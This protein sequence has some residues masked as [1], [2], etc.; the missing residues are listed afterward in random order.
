MTNE[1]RFEALISEELTAE[2]Q[3]TIAGGGN[4]AI[5][6]DNDN[7]QYQYQDNDIDVYQIK[8]KFFIFDKF[9]KQYLLLSKTFI[10]KLYAQT[11]NLKLQLVSQGFQQPRKCEFDLF[12]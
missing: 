3:E 11:Y 6:K 2:A 10:T 8:K 1:N 7:E 4:V 9:K 5:I 12:G